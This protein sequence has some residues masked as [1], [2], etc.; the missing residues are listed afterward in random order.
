MKITK[1][2]GYLGY[3][4]YLNAIFGSSFLVI[5]K[6]YIKFCLGFSYKN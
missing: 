4:S 1:Y 2:L 6:F 3:V 5:N